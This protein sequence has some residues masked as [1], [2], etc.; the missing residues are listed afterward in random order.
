MD[1]GSSWFRYLCNP[2]PIIMSA[3]IQSDEPWEYARHRGTRCHAPWT[4][5]ES[6]I[7]QYTSL[8]THVLYDYLY[9][10]ADTLLPI[11]V[12]DVHLYC[13]FFSHSWRNLLNFTR[14]E[15]WVPTPTENCRKR[16]RTS[17]LRAA[18]HGRDHNPWKYSMTQI[19]H[20]EC[21][22]YADKSCEWLE[23]FGQ[24]FP[25]CESSILKGFCHQEIPRYRLSP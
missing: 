3:W 7:V 5:R 22:V 17:Q 18:I 14:F 10:G 21:F 25:R 24:R 20:L 9:V 2:C 19:Y 4:Y 11:L 15:K 8:S 6:T 1:H 23:T 13:G 16:N 12:V